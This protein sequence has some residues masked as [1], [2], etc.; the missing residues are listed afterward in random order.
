[1]KGTYIRDGKVGNSYNYLQARKTEEENSIGRIW[2][3]YVYDSRPNVR[4]HGMN[5][6]K[7]SVGSNG[8]TF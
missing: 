8:E 1:V 2:L 5:E 3:V 4:K 6:V 7:F